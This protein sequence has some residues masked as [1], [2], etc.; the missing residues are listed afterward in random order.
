M[1][2]IF[3]EMGHE[4]GKQFWS[5]YNRLFRLKLASEALLKTLKKIA[6]RTKGYRRTFETDVL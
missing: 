6:L 4:H 2:K 5:V 3:A 1:S